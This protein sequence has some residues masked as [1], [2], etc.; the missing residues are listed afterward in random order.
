MTLQKSMTISSEGLTA[1]S[2]RL[3]THANNIANIDTPNYVRKIPVLVENN[4]VSFEDILTQMRGGIIQTGISFSPNGVSM[5]GVIADPTPGKRVYKPGH[6][7]ADKDGYVV[8][9]N[10][11]PMV[12][13]ADATISARVYEANLAVLNIAK[14]MANRALEIGRGQ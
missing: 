8:M 6:P 11:N 12:D 3:K 9:S 5:P 13:I 1:Q 14:T 4:N 7:D 2:D 10:V